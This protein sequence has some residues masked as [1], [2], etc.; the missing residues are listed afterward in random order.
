M[1]KKLLEPVKAGR[2]TLKTELCFRHLRKY[3]SKGTVQSEKE[4]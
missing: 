1:I 2:L 3:M 4:A